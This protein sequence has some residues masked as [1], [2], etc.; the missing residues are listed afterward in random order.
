M[1]R[2]SI[3]AGRAGPGVQIDVAGAAGRVPG[4]HVQVQHAGDVFALA[5]ALAAHRRRCPA[6]PVLRPSRARTAG[7]SPTGTGS[8]CRRRPA[9]ATEP[10]ALS[11]A[12]G[13][14][15]PAG[16]SSRCAPMM[17][18]RPGFGLA[19]D[20]ADNVRRSMQLHQDPYSTTWF[21]TVS[22]SA[23]RCS[24]TKRVAFWIG[25]PLSV[26]RVVMVYGVPPMIAGHSPLS[27]PI[28]WY[29]A[30]WLTWSI[31]PSGSDGSSSVTG[32]KL[33][34]VAGAERFGRKADPDD[35][36]AVRGQSL[37]VARGSAEKP[38]RAVSPAG[39]RPKAD[40]CGVGRPG[41]AVGQVVRCAGHVGVKHAA[42]KSGAG[43]PRQV[44]S[45]SRPSN[46][47]VG[48]PVEAPTRR[49][50]PSGPSSRA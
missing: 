25:V 4:D 50:A 18:I 45:V 44:S 22:P 6:A 39:W 40:Q 24:P 17:K 2:R 26:L 20:L 9:R 16:M 32:G 23:A 5:C 29:N 46:V 43:K 14:V 13:A 30:V 3:V 41:G 34:A 11:S 10:L 28:Y 48:T 47:A 35:F 15:G 37:G 38:A 42:G 27:S 7:C 33:A 12:P 31:M 19:R 36:G 21:S 49:A 8:G 1:V